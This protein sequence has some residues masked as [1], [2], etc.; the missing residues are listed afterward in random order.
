[1]GEHSL[2]YSLWMK[3]WRSI[4]AG[5]DLDEIFLSLVTYYSEQTRFYHNLWHIE[6]CLEELVKVGFLNDRSRNQVALAIWFHDVIFDPKA[7]DNEE[8]SWNVAHYF[9]KEMAVGEWMFDC[10]R[11]LILATKH[12]QIPYQKDEQVLVDIDLSILGK[13]A[14]TFDKYESAIR[15][16][17]VWVNDERYRQ[18]RRA[19]LR[20][21]L[22]R[23]RIYSTHFFATLYEKQARKNLKRALRGLE[24]REYV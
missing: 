9:L 8:R 13:D 19:V 3:L 10:Q 18:G 24:R 21:F 4:E 23:E 1:M 11:R 16:E 12:Q 5:G 20:S 15:K 2:L 6:N 22:H 7:S 14:I 17:Y